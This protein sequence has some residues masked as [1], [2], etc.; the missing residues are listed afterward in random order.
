MSDFLL[1][2]CPACNTETKN[3][4][5]VQAPMIAETMTIE[6]LTPY[7]NGF[8]KEK[9]FFSY[10]RCN[11]CGLLYCPKFF[12]PSQ[13]EYLYAQMPDNTA[14]VSIRTLS[15]TQ[16]G[17][18]SFFRKHSALNGDYIEI[19]PDIGLF[20]KYCISEGNFNH[21][22]LFEPNVTV[23]PTLK[24]LLKDSK[25]DL[26]G[27]MSN[28][29][30]LPNG[31]ASTAVLIH[32]LDHF[33]NPL[34]FLTTIRKKLKKEGLLFVV[35]HDESSLMAQVLS[36][37]WPPFCLQHPQLYRPKTI[38]HLFQKAGFKLIEI[39]KTYNYFPVMYLVK[40][41]FWVMGIKGIP[42]PKWEEFSLPLKLGNIVSIAKAI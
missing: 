13:L 39:E 31:N 37:R 34:E 16:N 9:S 8:F 4:L 28:F 24:G 20:T 38:S 42:L 12:S 35:T 33:L 10:Y 32:V 27:E 23:W 18:F 2:L 40:H 29:D 26:T 11:E 7:W 17:Y 36:S 19:G 21:F 1:R 6:D 41:M 25:Y 14:G 30:I 3:F 15:K 5:E 22:W